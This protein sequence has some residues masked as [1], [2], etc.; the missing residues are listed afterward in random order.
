MS[1]EPGAARCPR[2]FGVFQLNICI[3]TIELNPR[4]IG[5]SLKGLVEEFYAG[6]PQL[7]VALA[8]YGLGGN[9]EGPLKVF[10]GQHKAAAQILLGVKELPVR[11]SLSPTLRFSCKLIPTLATR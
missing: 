5:G 11:L 2:F 9:A 3:T 8:W 1:A 10:D 4:T 7:H 6:R